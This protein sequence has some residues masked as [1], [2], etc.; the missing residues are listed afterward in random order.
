MNSKNVDDYLKLP[1]TIEM[2]KDE[3]GTLLVSVKELEGCM[4][5]GATPDEAYSMI[6]DAMRAWIGFH[7]EK[8]LHIPEPE[9]LI[10]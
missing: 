6:E 5:D 3:D 1:Y 10:E 8:D 2:K 4:S 9:N 7:L